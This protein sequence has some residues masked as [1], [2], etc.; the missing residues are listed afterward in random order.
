MK[1]IRLKQAVILAGGRGKRLKPITNDIPKPMALIKGIPFLD[2]LINS[3][4]D[5]GITNILILTGYK[6]EIIKKRYR[7]IKGINIHFS[8]S[9]I[10]ADTG[11][12]I[13]DAHDQLDDYFLLMYGDNYWPLDLKNMLKLYCKKEK[14]IS[15]TVFTNI[16][17]T[18]EYGVKNNICV[19]NN[20]VTSYDKKFQNKDSNGVDIGYFI[21]SKRSLYQFSNYNL[22][23]EK[24]I[25][26]SMINNND[27]S[28]YL[29]NKQY[30]YIT[31]KESLLYFESVI[32]E[33]NFLPLSRKFF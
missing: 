4:I 20:L 11:K 9:G 13:L 12:R 33:N 19:K 25:L 21:V 2:Y 7:D 29:T 22:S 30:Y 28:A 24:D 17:G 16:N 31:N 14:K 6:H 26:T 10:S 8:D 3:L 32:S 27:L 18:G 1:N 15:T 23:F 5:E